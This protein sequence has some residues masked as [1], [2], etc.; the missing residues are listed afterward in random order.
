[1]SEEINRNTER[2]NKPVV[3]KKFI[4]RKRLVLVSL[5]VVLLL[6]VIGYFK[7]YFV[8]SE[9]TRVGILYKFS[10][11]GTFFKTYEGE[12]VLPGVRSKGTGGVNS[13]MFKFSVSDEEL[14]NVLMNSQGME[15]ELHYSNYNNALPWRGDNYNED[16]G[17]YIVDA[18]IKVKDENP[19]GYGL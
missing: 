14:A 12:M 8:Y 1:M 17:Q 11:K 9:G 5:G 7:Y 2:V 10:K 19:N 6:G 13:N 18:L 3:K 16:E 15:L 4:W